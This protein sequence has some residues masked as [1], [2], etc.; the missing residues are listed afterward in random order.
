MVD[1]SDQVLQRPRKYADSKKLRLKNA[2]GIL[3]QNVSIVSARYDD[4]R[5]SW[6]Y[7]LNDWED[8]RIAD[9][10]EETKLG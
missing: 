3:Q 2:Q 10:A 1:K 5:H 4:Q 9:E 8:Q 6:M 7:T